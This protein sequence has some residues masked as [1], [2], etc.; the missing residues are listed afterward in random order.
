MSP[1]KIACV[2]DDSPKAQAALKE[3]RKHYHIVPITRR[4]MQAEVI[5]V[6]GGDGF[7][8][9]TLH[10]YMK[11]KLPFYGLNCGTV[12]FLM[13]EYSP[14][15]LLDRIEHARAATLYPLHMYA[16]CLN[17][18]VRQAL[19]FNEVSLFRQGRQA[20][21]IRVSIDHVVRLKELTCDGVLVA[22]PA[23]STAYNFSAGGPIIPLG[24]NL[25]ALTPLVPFRPRRWRG[26]L[27]PHNSSVGF[28]ILEPK[29]R[30]V[31]AVADFTE[32]HDV[33]EVVIGEQRKSGV[34]LL[35]D[36]EHNLEERIIK[37]Q[38]TY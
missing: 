8:L 13:N 21:K 25:I 37:E 33:T 22:T 27:L 38:F 7:M 30:P 34:T 32:I 31:N 16:R 19:A 20:A 6:L 11:M 3:I 36:P 10:Q 15:G 12:G 23:G 1:T 26:A 35:F 18:K 28:T 4:R 2:A 14:E 24:A 29:K 17:G 5:V 9:Q